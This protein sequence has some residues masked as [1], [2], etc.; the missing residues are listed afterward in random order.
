[1]PTLMIKYIILSHIV[2]N[3]IILLFVIVPLVWNNENEQS[4]QI[5]K[6]R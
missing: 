3:F 5:T 1:M 6:P 2:E 4:S